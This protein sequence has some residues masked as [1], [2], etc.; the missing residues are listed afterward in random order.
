M[1]RL[2]R[3]LTTV[4]VALLLASPACKPKKP[5]L[6]KATETAEEMVVVDEDDPRLGV[7]EDEYD[8]DYEEDEDYE[9]GE[10][11]SP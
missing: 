2:V 10:P 1:T 3:L 5:R 6:V 11:A 8:D 9:T 4:V 7:D